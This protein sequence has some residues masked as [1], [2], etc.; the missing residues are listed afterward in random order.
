MAN[1]ILYR[2]TGIFRRLWLLNPSCTAK[3]IQTPVRCIACGLVRYGY[4]SSDKWTRYT[5][6]HPSLQNGRFQSTAQGSEGSVDAMEE[7]LSSGGTLIDRGIK[8]LRVIAGPLV[9]RT[10]L[11]GSARTMYEC[12]VEGMKFEEFFED[13]E[14]PDTFQSWFIILHLHI[15]MCLVR[16]KA[17]GKDGRYMYRKLVEMMWHDV[18]ER[19]KNLGKI[20]S[21]AV[22]DNL[23]VLTKQFYGLTIA[24]DEGLLCDDNVLAAALWRNFFHNKKQTDAE[25]LARMVEYIR[26]NVQH[27]ETYS[28]DHLLFQSGKFTWLPFNEIHEDQ[29]EE[30][31]Q[32]C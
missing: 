24:F 1:T 17:E 14:L 3:V 29:E 7:K 5:S 18:E 15:W 16:L 9:K 25:V 28:R 11:V 22:R 2:S 31:E 30:K 19:M 26:K 21:V 20:D 12:C 8:V 23:R 13:C 32:R 10:V 4:G 27:L 6:F